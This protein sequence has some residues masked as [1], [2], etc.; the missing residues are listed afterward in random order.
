MG[1]IKCDPFLFLAFPKNINNTKIIEVH[2]GQI[3]D[4]ASDVKKI[5]TI[6]SNVTQLQVQQPTAVSQLTNDSGYQTLTQVQTR[7]DNAITAL[8]DS[9]PGTLNTLNELAAALGDD[10]N[11]ATSVT[12]MIA[13]KANLSGSTFTG[14]VTVNGLLEVKDPGNYYNGHMRVGA[15]GQGFPYVNIGMDE[16][17]T[18]NPGMVVGWYIKALGD[19][20]TNRIRLG[21][22]YGQTGQIIAAPNTYEA[23]W[24]T[25]KT[26][27]GTS[28]LGA[29]DIIISAYADSKVQTYLTANNYVNTTAL[30]TALS[31][32]ANQST[33]YTKT[34]TDTALALKANTSSLGT[35]ASLSTIDTTN[36]TNG[37]VTAAKLAIGAA[38]TISWV[39][40]NNT[41]S[42]SAWVKLC[43]INGNAND[44]GTIF[45][46]GVLG[47]SAGNDDTAGGATLHYTLGNDAVANNLNL[48]VINTSNIGTTV[49]AAY[50]VRG[51]TD[52][53]WDIWVQVGVYTRLNAMAFGN[54]YTITN[55]YT[56]VTQTTKPTGGYD[57]KVGRYV[58]SLTPGAIL[59]V[60][61]GVKTD[62]AVVSGG[63][64][65]T[66]ASATIT[67]SSSTNKILISAHVNGY[68]PYDATLYFTRNGTPVGQ[69]DA[70][71]T[72]ARG[73]SEMNGSPRVNEA[74]NN[75]GFYLDSPGTTGAVTYA[76]LVYNAS[77]TSYI[78]RSG[79]DTDAGYDARTISTI[80]LM[81]VAA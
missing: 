57:K 68:S 66:I 2:M 78:N 18:D 13:G 41:A 4:I 63:V 5:D 6:E 69:G 12:N 80:T 9:A 24:T 52:F 42:A 79:S 45:L 33:T 11:F 75:A 77:A 28:I 43:T 29:G 50:A 39:A 34:E 40:V 17:D 22:V 32:K 81:E 61:Q 48:N 21:G 14:N 74:G 49:T 64:T 10:P 62:T 27:N 30:N 38:G 53:I 16:N 20:I 3:R 36:I 59:Q 55:T 15:V 8:V 56:D 31:T 7:V 71:G 76:V 25:I 46:S 47:Y 67:P 26:V 44:R 73:F 72:R 35:L 58:T 37:A 54:I 1:R 65:Y 60:A 19:I 23:Q 51:A 70:A